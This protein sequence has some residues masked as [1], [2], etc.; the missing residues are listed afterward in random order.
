MP[1]DDPGTWM[2]GIGAWKVA[3]E[4]VRSTIAMLRDLRSVGG[5]SEEEKKVIDTALSVASANTA[6]AE[7]QLAKA[8]GY[9][10]CKCEFPPTP[11]RTVGYFGH[12]HGE[13]RETDPVYE[14]PKCGSTNAGPFMYQRT[15]PERSK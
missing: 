8:F 10:L 4:S 3:V 11:M 5:G 1:L 7:A 12:R 6:I 15:A 9:E 2:A 14:C 13:H